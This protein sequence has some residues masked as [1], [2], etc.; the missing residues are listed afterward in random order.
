MAQPMSAENSVEIFFRFYSDIIDEEATETLQAE[1]TDHDKGYYLVKEIPFYTP[2]IAFGDVVWAEYSPTEGKLI[3][4]ATA[5]HSGNS[6][7]HV[8]ILDEQHHADTVCAVFAE[9]GCRTRVFN[10]KCFVINILAAIEYQ[11]IKNRLDVLTKAGVIY[12]A[13]LCLSAKHHDEI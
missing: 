8:V 5:Q 4:R 10:D 13:E 9:T 1:V 12:Y 3:Y 7:I 11:V 6:T 2:K